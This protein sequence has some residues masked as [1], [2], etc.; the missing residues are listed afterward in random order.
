[1]EDKFL[2]VFGTWTW[3]SPI[4]SYLYAP[5]NV[6]NSILINCYNTFRPFSYY[7]SINIERYGIHYQL[8]DTVLDHLRSKASIID[9]RGTGSYFGVSKLEIPQ[10]GVLIQLKEHFQIDPKSLRMNFDR[11]SKSYIMF[12][13]GDD[14]I[15]GTSEAGLIPTDVHTGWRFD[16]ILVSQVFVLPLCG[17]EPHM[18]EDL[19]IDIVR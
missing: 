12:Y 17:K 1:M 5:N 3:T 19:R 6:V 13:V 10:N 18:I 9:Y 2:S 14:E 15:I 11:K 16:K 8:D 7:P 4:Q